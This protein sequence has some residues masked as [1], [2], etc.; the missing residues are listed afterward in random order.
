MPK[1]ARPPSKP[2]HPSPPVLYA[3]AQGNLTTITFL[4]EQHEALKPVLTHLESLQGH[5]S[6]PES[7]PNDDDSG[8]FSIPT[9]LLPQLNVTYCA[10]ELA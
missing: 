4:P 3:D 6:R 1:T 7:G 5:A 9:G 2:Q 8:G 10:T